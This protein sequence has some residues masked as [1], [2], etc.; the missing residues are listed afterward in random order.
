MVH[1]LG[2]LLNSEKDDDLHKH[3]KDI[4]SLISVL[5]TGLRFPSEEIRGEVLFVLYKLSVLQSTLAEGEG[6]DMLIPFCPQ[7]LYLLVD[8]LMETDDVRL[9][10]IALLTILA[11][12]RLLR[13]ECAYDACNISSNGGVNSKETEDGTRGT[14]LVNLFAEAIK[15]PLRRQTVKFKSAL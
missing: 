4:C 11:R 5:V 14:S 9:N 7:I 10:C 1:C 15:G 2:A 6:S 12:R 13:E 8:V 3:I